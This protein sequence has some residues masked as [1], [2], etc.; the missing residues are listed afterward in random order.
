MMTSSKL[1]QKSDILKQIFTHLKTHFSAA[2]QKVLEQFI[3]R[4]YRDVTIADLTQMSPEDLTGLTVSLWRECQQWS[5]DNAKVLVFN[6]D[7]EKDEWQSS[8]TVISVLC[9]NIPFVIDTLKLIINE[10]NIKVHRVFHSEMT[11]SR[12]KT[13]K[14]SSFNGK[15][16]G[17]LLL[18]LEID[19]TSSKVERDQLT[20]K[21][22]LAM[23]DV[24]LVVDDFSRLTQTLKDAVQ[25][26]CTDKYNKQIPDLKEQQTFLSWLLNDH[27]TFIACDQFVIEKGQ[28]I[29]SQESRLGLLKRVGF[30]AELSNS[31]PLMC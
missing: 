14:L 12:T 2:T 30:M 10:Q 9:R 15:E 28:L 1:D 4:L 29:S 17:E 25:V 6:P 3:S 26:S 21:I 20:A 23:Q 19:Q 13:G 22:Q 18:Y 31:K 27:F 16:K 5:G 8:H 11:T 7:V 24:V